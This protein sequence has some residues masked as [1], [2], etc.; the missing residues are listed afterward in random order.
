MT[1]P[2]VIVCTAQAAWSQVV[3]DAYAAAATGLRAARE[4][5]GVTVGTVEAAAA[6]LED[7][8]CMMGEIDAAMQGASATVAAA[9]SAATGGDAGVDVEEDAALLHEL[10]ALMAG[11]AVD[12]AAAG[13]GAATAVAAAPVLPDLPLPLPPP[14]MSVTSAAEETARET[15]PAERQPL[16]S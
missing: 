13:P 14:A 2:W 16:A 11:L 5:S 8:I 9:S 4:G 10:E 1:D 15:R 7:E 3:V 12:A 6:A